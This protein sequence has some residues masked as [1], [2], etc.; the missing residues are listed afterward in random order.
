MPYATARDKSLSPFDGLSQMLDWMGVAV[1]RA[2]S[3]LMPAMDVSET[4]DGLTISLELPGMVKDDLDVTLENGVL[5]VSGEKT[6]ER[7]GDKH[8]FHVVERRSGSFRRTVTLPVDVDADQAD[9]S[10]ENGVLTI[11]IPKSERVKPR[12][13]SVK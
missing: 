10:F 5:S 1:P 13:L 6:I 9:A 2:S 11:A 4:E 3:T 8:R 12:R 7:E